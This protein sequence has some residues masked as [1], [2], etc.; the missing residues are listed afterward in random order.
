MMNVKVA[1]CAH[2]L[3]DFREKLDDI[4]IDENDKFDCV[5]DNTLI[6][7][8]LICNDCSGKNCNCNID[9]N[10][11]HCCV[12]CMLNFLNLKIIKILFSK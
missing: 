5:C 9:Q 7:L 8:I 2:F 1:V 10:E 3:N 6:K 4:S 12:I 11:E